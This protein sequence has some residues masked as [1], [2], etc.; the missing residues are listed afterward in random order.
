[1]VAV[2]GAEVD[3]VD[4][5]MLEV[6]ERVDWLVQEARVDHLCLY[7]ARTSVVSLAVEVAV[8]A[9]AQSVV[10]VV[11]S[12]VASVVSSVGRL[13]HLVHSGDLDATLRGWE[14]GKE[15]PRWMQYDKHETDARAS[16]LYS[17]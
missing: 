6:A 11:V 1:M 13:G 3:G 17:F 16:L 15:L 14:D 5:T 12:V 10:V 2:E 7:R 4:Q 9:E 8:D